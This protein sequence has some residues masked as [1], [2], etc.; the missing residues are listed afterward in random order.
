MVAPQ[1]SHSSPPSSTPVSPSA[2]FP[3]ASRVRPVRSV[4]CWRWLMLGWDDLRAHPVI[5]IAYG[6]VFVL[7]AYVLTL[8]LDALGMLYLITPMTAGFLLVAP[9]LAVGLYE[10]S[11][12]RERGE[13]ISF[14]A[15]LGAWRRNAFHLLTAGLV[16]MLFLMIWVRLAALI[17]AVSFPYTNMTAAGIS[18]A[19]WSW[20][21]AAFLGI[22]SVVG[23]VMALT[24]FVFGAIS[25]PMM[26]ER[27]V[28][29]FTAALISALAVGR[30]RRAMVLWAALLV[31]LSGLG[32][33]TAFFGLAL[34]VPLLGHATWHAY[35]AMVV[36]PEEHPAPKP[37]NPAP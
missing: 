1:T 11:R 15:A 2:A 19:L 13:V 14:W 23:G 8:G 36:W 6:S 31:G 32:I 18:Q 4:D 9:A 26:V 35:R 24:A 25:L 21:G 29:V 22:G 28:D 37:Q 12:R 7:G 17:F 5:S 27:R 16:L 30:N 10:L 34:V 3:F 20:E 33:A